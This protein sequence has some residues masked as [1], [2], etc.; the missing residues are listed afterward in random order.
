MKK[1]KIISGM[2]L[3][4]VMSVGLSACS[5]DEPVKDNCGVEDSEV[6]AAF[7][8]DYW[9]VADTKFVTPDGKEYSDIGDVNV[10]IPVGGFFSM[11][12]L[13]LSGTELR[14]FISPEAEFCYTNFDVTKVDGKTMYLNS[15]SYKTIK[16][17]SVDTERITVSYWDYDNMYYAFKLNSEGNYEPGEYLNGA[18]MKSTLRNAT[19]EERQKMEGA[20]HILD[21]H[22]Q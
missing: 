10:S 22:R 7:G 18:Y 1:I 20:I 3:A 13:R 16:L 11:L 12:G 5:D 4:L 2:A 21:T 9:V 6:T 8:D 15:E 14:M 17:E 19:P